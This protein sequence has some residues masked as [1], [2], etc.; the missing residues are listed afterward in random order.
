MLAVIETWLLYLQ[1]GNPIVMAPV[2]NEGAREIFDTGMNR[3]EFYY[4][5]L[6]FYYGEV[7]CPKHLSPF[8]L[9]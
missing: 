7:K 3:T 4:K 6:Q 5:P 2:Q 9:I 1:I 8:D